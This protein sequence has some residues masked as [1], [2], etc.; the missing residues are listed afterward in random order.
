MDGNITI[1]ALQEAQEDTPEEIYRRH[2]ASGPKGDI[3]RSPEVM[4]HNMVP[5]FED[6]T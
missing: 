4:G 3:G 2:F 5:L 1:A 6:P